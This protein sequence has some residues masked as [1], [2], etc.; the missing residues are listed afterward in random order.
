MKGPLSYR[1]GL[2]IACILMASCSPKT[3]QVLEPTPTKEKTQI[4]E[5]QVL[6]TAEK[7]GVFIVGEEP[8]VYTSFQLSNPD[9]LVIDIVGVG[10]GK[11]TENIQIPEGPVRLITPKMAEEGR[12]ARLEMEL[13][14][15]VQT[16][17]K[18]EGVTLSIEVVVPPE[19]VVEKTEEGG[20]E[21]E[22]VKA[23]E[24]MDGEAA[25]DGAAVMEAPAAK[26][27]SKP[28][29]VVS[30]IR[31][32]RKEGLQLV[33]VSDG[34]L[35]PHPFYLDMHR[36]VIDLPAV[37]LAKKVEAISADDR[38]VKQVRV[39]EH[40]D[41]VRL[42]L[43]LLSPVEYFLRQVGGELRVSLK[44][45]ALERIEDRIRT[46]VAT[47]KKAKPPSISPVKDAI[48]EREESIIP[49][50][51]VGRKIS[52]DFQDA[53]ITDIIRLIAEVSGLNIVLGDEVKG[54]MTLKLVN[55]PWDQALE[56]ILK[57]NI[58]GQQRDG[59]IIVV[60]TLASITQRQEEEAKAKETGIRA[61]DRETRV[62]YL[63]YGITVDAR[64]NTMVV[65]DIA[66]SIEEVV[67]MAK[68]LDT[69]TPQVS[70]EA[71][72]VE[73]SP[74]FTQSLGVQWG[75]N[76]RD[77]ASNNLIRISTPA[78]G[79]PFGNP[80][81]GF[82]VNVPASNTLGGVGFTF[83]RFTDSPLTLDLRLSAGE[84]QGLTKIVSTP[85]ITVL[86]NLQAKISQGE[87]IPFQTT[88]S[89][90][91]QTTFIDA[92]LNLEVTPHIS[93]DGGIVMK[94]SIK[95]NSAG[96]QRSGA[97]PSILKKEAVTNVLVLD[98]ETIAIGGIQ[99]TTDVET[100]SGIPFLMN[101]PI[102]GNL[103]KNKEKRKENTELLV[104][105]TPK[106]VR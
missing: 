63:N 83:G 102:I 39:G 26:E 9:R 82:A 72:I 98:G 36:L 88:S 62:V 49:S 94:V 104:F 48:A 15:A 81:P 18:S 55:V 47:E 5:I 35:A 68:T 99:E 70:I 19:V 65:K 14:G 96:E 10:L 28:A 84:T 103:F 23:T 91:T 31:F 79:S 97:G 57:I 69:R 25:A 4:Q 33:V 30:D 71:R 89:Q 92:T 46:D 78:A 80:S 101:L 34:E 59:E 8:M 67:K 44:E 64:T 2:F 61:E 16:N 22:P 21:K 12:V 50:K 85:K 105:I 95:K 27:P 6:P 93:S 38:A 51:Y 40:P 56:T 58:L 1:M 74:K 53:E 75:A 43:D 7:T 73:V 100:I 41:K 86:D 17:V 52:L 11:F 42:V 90:G 29:E 54:K 60:S 106:I 87:S 32:D 66:A 37:R 76:Y 24:K 13:S 20:G 45:V 77:F 3:A